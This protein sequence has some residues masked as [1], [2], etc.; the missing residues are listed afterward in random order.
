MSERLCSLFAARVSSEI[1]SG[2]RAR[3]K[4]SSDKNI[5][6]KMEPVNHRASLPVEN[7]KCKCCLHETALELYT[8]KG[9]FH[10]SRKSGSSGL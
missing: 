10:L 8:V 4:F 9:T 1:A 3:H 6:T 5:L 2:T 7:S